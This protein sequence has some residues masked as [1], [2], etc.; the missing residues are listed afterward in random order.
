MTS[1][2]TNVVIREHAEVNLKLSDSCSDLR[3][4]S[5]E[6]ITYPHPNAGQLVSIISTSPSLEYLYLSTFSPAMAA[7]LNGT[8]HSARVV[9]PE[10]QT[11][12]LD[13]LPAASIVYILANIHIPA[14][15]PFLLVPQGNPSTVE[16]AI[17]SSGIQLPHDSDT[18]FL[19][20]SPRNGVY[21][22]HFMPFISSICSAVDLTNVTQLYVSLAGSTVKVNSSSY[23]KKLLDGLPSLESIVVHADTHQF[24]E[25]FI[26]ALIPSPVLLPGSDS[27]ST[28]EQRHYSQLKQCQFSVQVPRE[29]EMDFDV[30]VDAVQK[31][32]NSTDDRY[33]IIASKDRSD[34][35][36]VKYHEFK[37]GSCRRS[38]E[39]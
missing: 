4:L 2:S 30:I 5:L 9:L 37:G 27:E 20:I 23:W 28:V 24:I 29:C 32:C 34:G 12:I 16:L 3:V 21:S 33:K 13:D 7:P 18:K 11:F 17:T 39:T 36:I 31:L 15:A 25:E 14:S 10:M 22:K 8:Q 6:H 35:K 19:W 38:V 1:G 26:L